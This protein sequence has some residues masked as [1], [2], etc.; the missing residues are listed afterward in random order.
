MEVSQPSEEEVRKPRLS[1]ASSQA[2]QL[3]EQVLESALYPD[4]VELC[5][6][7]VY[8]KVYTAMTV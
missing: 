6:V 3:L 4:I 5:Q 1:Q 2:K 8:C 7:L